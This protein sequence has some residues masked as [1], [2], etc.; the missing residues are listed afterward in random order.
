MLIM[1][2]W[3]IAIH[4][5]Q[6]MSLLCDCLIINPSAQPVC[7]CFPCVKFRFITF[8]PLKAKFFEMLL[9]AVVTDEMF[10]RQTFHQLAQLI[11][12]YLCVCVCVWLAR[13]KRRCN[14]C[15]VCTQERFELKLSSDRRN[16]STGTNVMKTG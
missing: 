6:V 8:K 7:G 10:W 4:K 5:R 14:T 15:S 9:Q 3:M 12:I 11:F 1:E 13:S 2:F 16:N